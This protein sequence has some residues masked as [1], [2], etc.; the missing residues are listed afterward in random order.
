MLILTETLSPRFIYICN[1]LFQYA[2]DPVK[3]IQTE[4]EMG[5]YSGRIIN[6]S[7]NPIS[8]ESIHIRPACN[9]WGESYHYNEVEFSK[10]HDIPVL[11]PSECDLGFDIFGAAFFMLSRIEEYQNFQ[12]DNMGRFTAAQSVAF[13]FGFLKLPVVDLWYNLMRDKLNEKWPLAEVIGSPLNFYANASIDVDSAFAYRY[14]GTKRALGGFAKDVV[15]L[16]L[17]NAWKRLTCILGISPD[18]Y[19]TFDY[20]ERTAKVPLYYFFLLS[21]FGQYDKN[22][23]PSSPQLKALIAR[24]ND[25]NK[26]GCH[27][28]VATNGNLD[29]LKVERGR[30][31]EMIGKEC[32]NSRQHYLILKFPETYQNLIKAGVL[33]EY[34]MGY[35]DNVGFR[36]G[37]SKPFMWFDL[38]K[39]QVTNLSIYPFA[40]MD[41]T[42]NRHL[43]LTPYQALE[44][45]KSLMDTVQ[46]TGGMYYSFWHNESLSETR[47]WKGWRRVWEE[48]VQY[49]HELMNES[50]QS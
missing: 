33:H 5:N 20:I 36:A 32:E 29:K 9:L 19:D 45:I 2:A 17:N 31:S 23:P 35:T 21:D 24:L 30:M 8:S 13:K 25:K 1:I 3:F 7:Q 26:M 18:P 48:S 50:L 44:E 38:Q 16:N 37:T 39:N 10:L 49:S 46:K 43:K 6:Y 14:K 42:L 27:P 40:A 41:A 4:S 11:Y 12:P 22:V 47:E 28:G 15:A 34:S